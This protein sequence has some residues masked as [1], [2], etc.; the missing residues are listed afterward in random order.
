MKLWPSG[1][2]A[3][4]LCRQLSNDLGRLSAAL[5][6]L[7]P[8][9]GIAACSVAIG[10]EIIQGR[11]RAFGAE[12]E[13]IAED[14]QRGQEANRIARRGEAAIGLCLLMRSL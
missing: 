6:P 5:G 7:P 1:K 8:L 9:R 13:M 4:S 2:M 11:L 12:A 3:R 14:S 10:S